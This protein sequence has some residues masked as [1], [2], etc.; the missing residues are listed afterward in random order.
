MI[1]WTESPVSRWNIFTSTQQGR[2]RKRSISRVGMGLV[3]VLHCFL[4]MARMLTSLRMVSLAIL[5]TLEWLNKQKTSGILVKVQ[6]CLVGKYEKEEY[7]VCLLFPAGWRSRV[8]E[9]FEGFVQSLK[10]ISLPMISDF[11]VW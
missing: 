2:D 8:R 1:T 4:V 9:D 6:S 11:S 10:W 7:Q 5:P 3:V